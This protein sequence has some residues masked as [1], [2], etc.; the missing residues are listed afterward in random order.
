M[1]VVENE[2]PGTHEE[3]VM[4]AAAVHAVATAW[5]ATQVPQLLQVAA[6]TAV[7]NVLPATHGVH[8]MFAVALQ[9]ADTAW[10]AAQVPQ[11]LQAVALAALENVPAVHA[12]QLALAVD[13]HCTAV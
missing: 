7:E 4:S 12:V 9:A 11:A 2:T 8:V 10:P 6:L 13:V 5:P 3:H 1:V